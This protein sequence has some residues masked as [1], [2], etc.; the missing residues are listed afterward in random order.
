MAT[1]ALYAS[2]IALNLIYDITLRYNFFRPTPRKIT[3]SHIYYIITDDFLGS[4][5]WWIF[6]DIFLS[7][8]KISFKLMEVLE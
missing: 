6:I 2:V 3:V 8:I 1:R 5:T 7:R 4:K